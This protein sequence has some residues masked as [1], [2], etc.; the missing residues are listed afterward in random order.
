MS[1]FLGIKIL[2]IVVFDER[3]S[4]GG[5]RKLVTRDGNLANHSR[6]FAY[7][8]IALYMYVSRFEIVLLSFLLLARLL[9]TLQP[10]YTY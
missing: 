2:Y 5:V 8:I 4:V 6:T 1:Y 10:L 3:F 9:L 7:I